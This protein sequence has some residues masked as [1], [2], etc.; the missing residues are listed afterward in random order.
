MAWHAT[1]SYVNGQFLEDAL[2]NTVA[3][4]LVQAGTT[5]LEV[6]MFDETIAS[7]DPDASETYGSGAYV[8]GDEV[9]DSGDYVAATPL[10]LTGTTLT[11]ASGNLIFDESDL[12]MAWTGVT[13][14][15]GAAP[16][17]CIVSDSALSDRVLCAIKFGAADI[18]VSSGTFTITWDASLGIFYADYRTDV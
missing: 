5:T 4:D 12:T 18:P 17:G 14:A 9:A 16:I 3:F 11:S 2:S 6:R 10:T 8:V 7:Q 15:D 13:W 1:G